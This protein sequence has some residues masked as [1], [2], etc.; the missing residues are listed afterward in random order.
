MRERLRRCRACARLAVSNVPLLSGSV[1]STG[2]FV[3][4]RDL[5]AAASA[6]ASTASSVSPDYF[7]TMEMPLVAG[8]GFTDRDDQT[9]PKVGDHQRN[10]GAQ[11]LPER[12]PDR[13]AL[14]LEHREERRRSRSS[15]SLRD[16]KYDSVRD[17]V[18][19]TM[20]VPYLQARLG[21]AMFQVRTAGD[22]AAAI[23]AI[24]EAVRQIDPNL[25]L[26]DVS[27][28]V[29]QVEQAAAAGARVRAGV[30]DV[31]RRWRCCWP[32][33]ACSA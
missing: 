30:R 25:P 23:G 5:R 1:S 7:K 13:P 28:Q 33:S 8:R 19:P 24:R 29:E 16:A 10:R 20:Y 6:T 31:R 14:R 11:V 15:A 27:T 3:Q 12:E 22:P 4:G 17:E 26:M 2:I 9:A 21:D 18:P 32:R